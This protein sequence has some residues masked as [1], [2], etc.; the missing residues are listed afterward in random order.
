MNSIRRLRF[1]GAGL[2]SADLA[3]FFGSSK[4]SSSSSQSSSS[5]S[6]SESNV[7]WNRPPFFLGFAGFSSSS[8]SSSSPFARFLSA[9]QASVIGGGPDSQGSRPGLCPVG[10]LG[11]EIR[12]PVR[13]L[14]VAGCRFAGSRLP[15]AIRIRQSPVT[16]AVW[17][18]RPT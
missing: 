11:L 16:D 15:F 10:P 9:F 4:S 17:R 6:S 5:S 8:S 3:G 7:R 12:S 1:L 13:R 18:P 2:L 14:P